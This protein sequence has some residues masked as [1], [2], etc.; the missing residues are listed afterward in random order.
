[1]LDISISLL[2]G[3]NGNITRSLASDH[4]SRA[5]CAT[6]VGPVVDVRVMNHH[7][8]A[9]GMIHSSAKLNLKTRRHPTSQALRHL[10]TQSLP[11]CSCYHP[12][13]RVRR[14][15]MK[16]MFSAGHAWC[17]TIL[18]L[19]AIII[20]SGIAML[21][22]NGH[23]SMMGSINDPKDG[24]AVAKTLFSSAVVYA[25]FFVFCSGQAWLNSRQRGVQLE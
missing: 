22:W 25:V 21:F 24:K 9:W 10:R 17:C 19:A 16:P 5:V 11:P 3:R 8:V 18:S 15:A 13:R 2:Y 1:V 20:L 7:C 12:I 6:R 4:F 14:P 23:E